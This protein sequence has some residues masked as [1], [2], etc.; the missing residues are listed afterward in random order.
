MTM[1]KTLF[2][3]ALLAVAPMMS[4]AADT[5]VKVE[6]LGVRAN[7]FDDEAE[8]YL[9]EEAGSKMVL[10]FTAPE[11]KVFIED[12]AEVVLPCNDGS[13]NALDDA[14]IDVFFSRISEDGKKMLCTAATASLTPDGVLHLIGDMPV[15]MSKGKTK[16]PAVEVDVSKGFKTNVAGY[17]VEVKDVAP[18]DRKKGQTDVT[19][20]VTG[21]AEVAEMELEYMDGKDILVSRPRSSSVTEGGRESVGEYTYTID[22]KPEKMNLIVSLWQGKEKVNVPVNV[23]AD[24]SGPVK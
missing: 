19:I 17:E 14:K 3:A 20:K 12:T 6:V 8:E 11:G 13:G 22:K 7:F 24:L 21:M 15:T 4:P 9:N 1:Y 18:S 16:Q 5:P 2:L 23:K 10:R